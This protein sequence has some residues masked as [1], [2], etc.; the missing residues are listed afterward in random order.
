MLQTNMSNA[1]QVA[2]NVALQAPRVPFVS[3]VWTQHFANV[4]TRMS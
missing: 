3:Y 4:S 2:H 1:P